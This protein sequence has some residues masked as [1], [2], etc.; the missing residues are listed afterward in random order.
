MK[1]LAVDDDL[2]ILELLGEALALLGHEEV[3]TAPSGAAALELVAREK[4]PFDCILLDIQMPDM[5]GISLCKEIRAT[6][7]YARTPVIMLTAMSQ[8]DYVERAFKAGASDYVTK[9]FDFLELG[10][11]IRMAEKLVNE[12]VLVAE[13]Q[14]AIEK[15]RKELDA[16]Q[17]TTLAHPVELQGVDRAIGY[18]AFENY[19]LQLSRSSQFASTVFAVKITGIEDIHAMASGGTYLNIL[20]A[21][22]RAVSACMDEDGSLLSYRGGGVF[23]CVSHGK[24]RFSQAEIEW[25]INDRLSH[26]RVADGLS[27]TLSV[28]VGDR[29][30][31]GSITKFGSL[32]AVHKAVEKVDRN[33]QSGAEVYAMARR[34]AKASVNRSED[35]AQMNRVAFE[36]MLREALQEDISVIRR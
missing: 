29:T 7:G 18:M 2:T 5:D 19:I 36:A 6:Q 17:K 24:P 12:R 1:V 34:V 32:L 9:P 11:R 21:A 15:L 10:S 27:K 8:R 4:T 35:R 31:L 13:G 33:P 14:F 16:E 25:N 28:T 23:L 22:G 30:S 3:Y 26:S 20:N